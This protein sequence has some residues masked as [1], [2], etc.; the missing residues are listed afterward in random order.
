[1]NL[2]LETIYIH[3]PD[4]AF[5]FDNDTVWCNTNSHS[6]QIIT[7]VRWN[8]VEKHDFIVGYPDLPSYLAV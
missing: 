1:M 6:A 7:F 2:I 8:I 5:N 4:K 3:C